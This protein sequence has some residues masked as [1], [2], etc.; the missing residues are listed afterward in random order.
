MKFIELLNELQEMY[1]Q[2]AEQS[3]DDQAPI[4]QAEIMLAD[5]DGELFKLIRV[6]NS[7]DINRIYLVREWRE[8]KD[9]IYDDKL[10]QRIES[11]STAEAPASNDDPVD[12]GDDEDEQDG[13]SSSN[14]SND[15]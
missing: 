15:W 6:M 8:G 12:W 9:A 4:L 2:S 7:P 10:R 1:A 11:T 5:Q 13:S 3:P 14:D